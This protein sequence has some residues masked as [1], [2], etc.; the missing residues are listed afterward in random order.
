VE[1]VIL[2]ETC[3]AAGKLLSLSGKLTA[4]LDVHSERMLANLEA[5]G[6]FALSE[7]VMLAL[8]VRIGKQTAHTLVYETAMGAHTER[9]GL[10]EA[11]LENPQ[12][13][14]Y[15]SKDEIEALF[16]YR[17]HTGH[18]GEMVDQVLAELRRADGL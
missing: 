8:A 11:M 6:G 18:C 7:V 1:W 17:Q 10:K 4:N 13:R 9:R 15:L 16:D 5:T 2:A 3:M 12:I 14:A